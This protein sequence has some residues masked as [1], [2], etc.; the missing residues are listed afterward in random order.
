MKPK[1]ILAGIAALCALH[2][3]LSTARAQGTAFTYQ[4]QLQSGGS[5]ANG[6][7]DFTFA[8]FNNDSTN[9]GQ[10]G[11]TLTLPDVT[12]T[13]G[14][15]TASLN[16][17]SVFTGNATW[18]AIGVRTNGGANFVALN[19]LQELTPAPYALYAPNAGTA[20][21]AQSATAAISAAEAGVAG[22][23]YEVSGSDVIGQILNSSLPSSP[24]F[25]GTVTASAFFGN[26]NGLTNLN[27]ANLA[28]GSVGTG[29]LVSGTLAAPQILAGT[30]NT[31]TPNTSY[32]VTNATVT[33]LYLPLTANV[34]DVVQIAG[35]GTG[36][37]IASA[38]NTNWTQSGAPDDFWQ[39][40]ASSSDGTH[41]VALDDDN[42][43]IWTSTDS[44]ASWTETDAPSVD[45]VAVA[46][47]SDGTHLV[48]LDET[49]DAIWTSTNS[50]TN[51]TETGA[52]AENWE[53]VASSSD[54]THLVALDDSN[55]AIWT[56][57][58]SG[59]NWTETDA[60]SESWRSVASSSDGAA[61]VAVGSLTIY[62]STNSG[63]TWT[64]EVAP[65]YNWLTVA[66]SSDGTH[67][68]VAGAAKGTSGSI[69]TSTNAGATWLPSGAPVKNWLSVASSSDGTDLIA[70]VPSTGKGVIGGTGGSI[71][72]STNAG[73]TWTL[74]DV[75]SIN[76]RSVASSA[77]GTFLVAASANGG[78]YTYSFYAAIATGNQGTTASLQYLGNGQWGVESNSPAIP[79]GSV[80][81]NNATN[82][83]LTGTVSGDGSGLTGAPAVTPPP[84]MVLIAGG[85]FIMGNSTG[86]SDITD[87]TPL[88]IAVSP[89]YMDINPVSYSQ[90]L[91]VYYWA[92]NQGYGWAAAG[93]GQAANQPVHSI[94]WYGAVKWC[95]ARSQQAGLTPVYYTDAAMTQVY[96]NRLTTPYV[97]WSANGY[98]LPTEAE[99]EMAAR[100][101]MT[102]QRFPWGNV[103]SE[104]LANYEGDTTDYS[105]DLGPAGYN[106]VFSAGGVTPG[107]SPLG[108]F[109]ANGYGLYDM[110]GN[111]AE[112]CWDWYGTPY[113]Q[114]TTTNPTGPTTGTAR[115]YRGGSWSG[116]ANS[117]RSA[118]RN[119]TI[120]GDYS[121]S[122]GFRCVIGL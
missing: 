50:G 36:G 121:S 55:D 82:G 14:L 116:N 44:G 15:F 73:A 94:G 119:K 102:G 79:S 88:S 59:T 112:W 118:A 46:S 103:I 35:A 54:G 65:D 70:A 4:G 32:V 6:H 8:L 21:S 75:P 40:V 38:Y 45:W 99:W 48:A 10:I 113:G 3:A 13:N 7:Y 62:T 42:D 23:A 47:S 26:G 60:P 90:W 57:G 41:L 16:F 72:T 106:A 17:G 80:V 49:D 100:G 24:V 71:Y 97:N 25:S 9:S 56:S 68:V 37:W 104:G 95:N 12:V 101:G 78:I 31:A 53:G 18:L 76:W 11:G 122:V 22:V 63:T 58:N 67:L 115:V 20:V 61:L 84:G 92:T 85:A 86:D 107:T 96:T 51:W 89:F 5:A 27:G 91:S 120:P 93:A 108:Y 28:A 111:V 43:A 30:S 19:P 34:G 66:S 114:P 33:T 109:A 110:A 98:R 2:F 39:A 77:D 52:P 87:A 29:Q 81:A 64:P 83:V 105:Y 117:A 74:A 1:Y 69:Y